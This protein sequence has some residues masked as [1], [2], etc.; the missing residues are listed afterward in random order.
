MKLTVL[1]PII[2]LTLSDSKHNSLSGGELIFG[3]AKS[4]PNVIVKTN[5]TSIKPDTSISIIRSLTP[6]K[7]EIRYKAGWDDQSGK[8]ILIISGS[9]IYSEDTGRAEIFAYLYQQRM[10]DVWEQR[11]RINDFVDG[12]GCDLEIKLP[13]NYIHIADIDS[14]GI[15]ETSFIYTLDNRCDAVMI[16]TKMI[17]HANY[18]KYA[19]RGFTQTHLMPTEEIFNSYRAEEGLPPVSYKKIDKEL[20]KYPLIMELYSDMWDRFSEEQN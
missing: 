3:H 5:S 20:E 8:T 19:I 6:Y 10:D 7:G 11:W 15:A 14:N 1:L 16:E 4:V 12:I 18:K 13:T 17:I 9:R 2:L